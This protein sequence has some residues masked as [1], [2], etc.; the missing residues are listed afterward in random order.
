MAEGNNIKDWIGAAEIAKEH[1]KEIF[2]GAFV[3]AK[4]PLKDEKSFVVIFDKA[5]DHALVG[6]LAATEDQLRELKELGV[7]V[8][9]E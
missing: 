9:E 5:T 4:I 3:Q 7:E 1:G 8:K 2:F 6:G